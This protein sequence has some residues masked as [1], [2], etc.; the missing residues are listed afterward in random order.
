MAKSP[1]SVVEAG[2]EFGMQLSCKEEIMPGDIIET[3]KKE[4]K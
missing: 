4:I 1:V 2:N 3:F